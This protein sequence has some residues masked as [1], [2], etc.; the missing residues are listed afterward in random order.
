MART[1]PKT[2][3]ARSRVYDTARLAG[4]AGT[5]AAKQ[6]PEATLRRLTL[7]CLLWEDNAYCDGESVV[8]AIKA[9][10][11]IVP[12]DVVKN[13]AIEARKDQKL[14]HVPLLL[15]REMCRHATHR[16]HV[17][18]TLREVIARPD[19][20]AEFLAL[21]WKTN[22]GKKAIAKQAKL[23]LSDAFAKFNEYRL[24]K[25]DRQDRAVKL[26][27]V[28]FQCHAKPRRM[29]PGKYT[30]VERA[31]GTQVEL[32][33]QEQL[34]AR[35]VG[36][37]MA[38]PD[39]WEVAVSAAGSDAAAKTAAWT[40]LVEEGKL[41]AFAFLKNLRN[42]QAANVS[43]RTIADGM[44]KLSPDILLPIDF[45][46]AQK[47]APDLTRELEDLM[48]RCLAAWPK[49][50]GWTIF[51]VDVSG[52]MARPL[53]SK[54]EYRRMDAAAALAVLAAE[55]CEH[56]IFYATAGNDGARKHATKR[57]APERGF[58]LSDTIV[59]QAALLG[60]GGIFTRQ[61]L[62]YAARDAENVGQ[63][64]R[65]IVFSDSQ[66]MDIEKAKPPQPFGKYNYIADVSSEQRGVNY[67]GVW[68]AEITGWSEHL[69]KYIHAME[70][71]PAVQ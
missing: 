71:Q 8:E 6:S 69:L 12:A 3:A 70:P 34:F 27:D 48:Y 20:L 5:R 1:N 21:Y 23:G 22:D 4:G 62:E 35:L 13:I 55:M 67:Q 30:K 41:G 14:R 18:E 7:A 16:P 54:S 31:A 57:I 10:V 28:L 59:R 24:A 38:T 15:A 64:D 63:P 11:P 58:A 32:S 45:L 9:Y 19:E 65:I 46:K 17:R 25:W 44:S 61:C 40:R 66:D 29:Q 37:N 33:E 51:I 49:L 2:P 52:S 56:V 26:R 60:G 68:T 47:Y 43:L 39:T 42:M 36:G 53:S 50:P